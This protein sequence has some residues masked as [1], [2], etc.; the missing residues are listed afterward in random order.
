MI[1]HLVVP[2]VASDTI[3]NLVTNLKACTRYYDRKEVLEHHLSNAISQSFTR[4]ANGDRTFANAVVVNL[5]SPIDEV[6]P[7]LHEDFDG[8]GS[9]STMQTSLSKAHYGVKKTS[10]FFRLLSL[11]L[12]Y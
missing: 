2:P 6:V 4:I 10:V 3:C 9:G 12:D 5:G 1:E 11:S 8:G 7:L